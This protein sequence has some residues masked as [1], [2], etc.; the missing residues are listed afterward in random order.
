MALSA[1]IDILV[2][3]HYLIA[4]PMGNE[5]EPA[6]ETVRCVHRRSILTGA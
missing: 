1:S 3:V 6:G 2:N 4:H 5:G